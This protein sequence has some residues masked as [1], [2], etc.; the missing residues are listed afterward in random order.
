[1]LSPSYGRRALKT[2]Q[3]EKTSILCEQGL[4][5]LKSIVGSLNVDYNKDRVKQVVQSV[6]LTEKL[7]D[8]QAIARTLELEIRADLNWDIEVHAQTTP[9]TIL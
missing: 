5:A 8:I 7:K 1:M 3:M 4:N 9:V 2:M 6:Q